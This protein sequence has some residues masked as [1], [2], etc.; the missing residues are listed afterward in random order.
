MQDEL[1]VGR[2]IQMSMVP[3]TFPPFP[4][5]TEFSIYAALHPA[6]EVGGDFYDY[7]FIDE[8]RVCACIGDVSGKGVPA[9]LFMAVSR[10]LLKARAMDDTSTASIITRVN[11]ELSRDN[12]QFMFVT[13]FTAIL[14]V[15]SGKLTYTNAGHNPPILRNGKGGT[16]LLDGRH[17]P[18][19]GADPGLAYKESTVQLEKGDLLLMYT[20]GITEARS[21]QRAFYG[22]DRLLDLVSHG[23]GPDVETMI[24]RVIDSVKSFENGGEQFD[25][26]T[27]V[28]LQY[29]REPG[30]VR[31]RV[32]MTIGND[33]AG[34]QSAK[35]G[36]DAFC[37]QIGLAEAIR[38]KMNLVLDELISNIV[39]YAYDDGERHEI[40]LAFELAGGRLT[41][42]IQDDGMPFNPF[43]VEP[44]DTTAGLDERPIGGLGIH[45][46][47]QLMDKAIY[48]RRVDGNVVTLVNDV[49]A[50]SKADCGN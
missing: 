7:F 49:S 32:E 33:L 46:V 17:G 23:D 50:G 22:D 6:R 5:R 38:R 4:E 44:P 40:V 43:E 47:R 42:T 2:D 15:V 18:V 16:I 11:D 39:F 10:T 24:R 37:E 12:E 28:A 13:V 1:N 14:D 29:Q 45:L 36:F 30:A 34:I 21:P 48:Q 19:L 26:I 31:H 20:D 3:R 9:A 25:D 8:N 41:V 27:A 35:A